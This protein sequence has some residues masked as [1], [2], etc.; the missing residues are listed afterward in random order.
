[1]FESI[2][3]LFTTYKIYVMIIIAALIFLSGCYVTKL[4]YVNELK[5]IEIAT[6]K[7]EAKAKQLEADLSAKGNDIQLKFVKTYETIEGKS[8]ER[9]VEVVKYVPLDKISTG[10]VEFYNAGIQNRDLKQMTEDEIKK[11]SNIT[12]Q[13]LALTT[14]KNNVACNK[15]IEQ[16]KALQAVARE[17][18][19]TY[20]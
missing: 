14:N 19:N 13:Q 12:E 4:Y 18:E 8:K 9:V 16:L 17:I 6:Q 15:Y 11:P 3:L 2:K 1:M 7:A 5:D 20:K 10:V